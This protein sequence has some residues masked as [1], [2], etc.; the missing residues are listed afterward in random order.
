MN[1]G[2]TIIE[3]MT[4]DA[5][6]NL[7]WIHNKLLLAIQCMDENNKNNWLTDEWMESQMVNSKITRQTDGRMES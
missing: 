4:R 2:S 7:R 1:F 6:T 3:Y 5:Q